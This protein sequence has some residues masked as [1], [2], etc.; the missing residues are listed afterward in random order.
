MSN[1]PPNPA[2]A[3]LACPFHSYCIPEWM[4]LK[5]IGVAPGKAWWVPKT[6][7]SIQHLP[8]YQSSLSPELPSIWNLASPGQERF[9]L[10][11]RTYQP[12]SQ[13]E[14][15]QNHVTWTEHEELPGW[16]MP[17]DLGSMTCLR[18]MQK[19]HAPSHIPRH[20]S[21]PSWFQNYILL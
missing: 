9:P 16:S 12:E 7:H 19:L 11:S 15:S 5:I 8:C 17:G 1:A 14:L 20:T 4:R 21:L 3:P 13:C 6:L 18:R 10:E 2:P